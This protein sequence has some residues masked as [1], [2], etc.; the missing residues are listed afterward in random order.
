MKIRLIENFRA[1]FY[2]PFYATAEL[3]AYRAEGLEVEI[4]TAGS[5]EQTHRML[6]TGGAQMSWGGPMRIMLARDA[7]PTS[8]TVAFCEVVGR[9]PFFLLGRTPNPN[10]RM[11]DLLDKK[12]ATVTEV[13]TPWVCLQHDLRAA[14]IDPAAVTRTRSR[15]MGENVELLRA[16][17]VD[18]IQV[19][20]PFAQTL[21]DE[22]AAHLW[23]VAASRGPACYTTLNTTRDFIESNADTLL[24][25]ARA[26]YRAQKWIA[27][28]SGRELADI[29]GRYLPDI[30]P[31]VLAAC[32]DG[33]KAT[34]VWSR[35]P[36]VQRAGI[37]YKREAMLSSGSIKTGYPYEDYVDNRF[38][39]AAVRENP[40]SI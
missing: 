22:G 13:P 18:V 32:C 9:D 21:L 25:M 20:Q 14:G 5:P 8:R 7:D 40:P 36:L 12:V 19:F 3:G 1:M 33:Y 11:Q 39:E 6:G 4:V 10:F 2:T 16:G 26:V 17:E 31:P 35:S 15:T 29:V 28:H 37:E 24:A 34:H 30:P 38:A 23:Y 27:A